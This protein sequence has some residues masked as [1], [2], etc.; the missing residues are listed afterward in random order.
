MPVPE[1]RSAALVVDHIVF[2][3]ALNV[4]VDLIDSGV[5][6]AIRLVGVAGQDIFWISLEPVHNPRDGMQLDFLFQRQ[7]VDVRAKSLIDFGFNLR[8][9][10]VI[11]ARPNI[12]L[13]ER[14]CE[15]DH[16]FE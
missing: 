9:Q 11:D 14:A 4:I 12:R 15:L 13:A 8:N 2:D 3:N 7:S 1:V 16:G 5:D 6:E 10:K